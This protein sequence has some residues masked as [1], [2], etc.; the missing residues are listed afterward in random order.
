LKVISDKVI[1]PIANELEKVWGGVESNQGR[2][3]SWKEAQIS[4]VFE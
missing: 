4:R 2:E 1:L 3:Y